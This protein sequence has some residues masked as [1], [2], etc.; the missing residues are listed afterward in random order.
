LPG[1]TTSNCDIFYKLNMPLVDYPS[2]DE[3]SIINPSSDAHKDITA[4]SS[5]KKRKR[6]DIEPT[7][8]TLPPLPPV[9]HTLFVTAPR[10][11]PSDDPSLHGGRTRQVP[12]VEGNWPTHIYLECRSSGESSLTVR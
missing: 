6:E 8:E 9:F 5:S 3:E 10:T 2:S 7:R 11:H 12:H 4:V 1:P